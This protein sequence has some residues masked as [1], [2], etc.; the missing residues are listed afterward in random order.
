MSLSQTPSIVFPVLPTISTPGSTNIDQLLVLY[1]NA[2]QFLNK[3]DDL[4]M[5]IA[6]NAPHIILIT[7][8]LP[9]CPNSSVSR[10]Q[11]YSPFMILYVFK[12]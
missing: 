2:D 6:G 11:L 1:T 4:L 5:F 10:S 9:K 8:V 3:R 7:E 12:F